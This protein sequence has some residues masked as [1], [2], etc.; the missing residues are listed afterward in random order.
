MCRIRSGSEDSPD[1]EST[2]ACISVSETSES[3]KEASFLSKH[4]QVKIVQMLHKRL[5]KSDTAPSLNKPVRHLINIIQF[6]SLRLPS[7]FYSHEHKVPS[8]KG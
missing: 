3:G 6:C 4:V 2:W 1:F 5:N 8:Q 7:V